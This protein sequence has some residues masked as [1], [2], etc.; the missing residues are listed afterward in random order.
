MRINRKLIRPLSLRQPGTVLAIGVSAAMLGAPAMAQTSGQDQEVELDTLKIEGRTAD[1][2]PYA[3][4]GAPYK[5]KVSGDARRTKPLAETPATIT[6]LTETAIEE[7]G[8]TDLKAILDAQPGITL[9]T[10]EGG[11]RFGD[12]YIIRGQETRSDVFVDGLRD[13]GMTT[14]ESFVVEQIEITKGPSATFAGRGASGGSV[15]G[16]TKQ[17]N[18]EYDFHNFDLTAGSDSHVRG[19]V[20]SNVRLSD[21]VA[22]RANLLYT[23]DDVPDRGVADRQRWGAALSVKANLSEA[24]SLLADYYHLDVDDRPDVGGIIASVTA[25]GKPYDLPAYTQDEDFMKSRIDI[26]TARLRIEPFDGFRIENTA[27]YGTVKNRYLV[28]ELS[29]FNR[30]VNDPYAGAQDFRVTSKAA[31]QNVSYFADQLNIYGEFTT[32]GL[33]H[34]LVAGVEY[35]DNKVDNGGYTVT[36]GTAA[37]C[38]SGNGASLNAWCI[39]DGTGGFIS[40]ISSLTQRSYTFN[41][42]VTGAWQVETMAGYV[43]DTIDVKP[44]LTLAGGVRFDSFQYS[45]VNRSGSTGL[46]SSTYRYHGTLWNYNASVTLKPADDGIVFFSWATG[47]DING[48]EADVGANCGYG[49]AC[50]AD[51]VLATRPER[52]ENYELGTKWNLFDE[53]LL[54]TASVFRTI[55]KDISEAGA[56]GSYDP[57]GSLYSGKHRV[58]GIELGVSGNIT[59]RLSAQAGAAFMKSKVLKSSNA[60]VSN[61]ALA[62]GYTNV[63]RRLANF[64][65]TSFDAQLRYQLTDRIAFGGNMTYQSKMYGGQPDTAAAYV[66]DTASPYFGEYSIKVPG[67][68]TY[69]AFISYKV[70]DKLSLRLNGLNL[71]DKTYY[72][73]A[74]RSGKFAYL[75]DG[76]TV[77]L[78]LSGKF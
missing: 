73:A 50:V 2:N 45:L 3:E 16:I 28:S 25:G 48:G 43:M 65:N 20:D 30:G 58:Q 4:E 26:A 59:E 64:A 78:T 39:G 1:V 37:N 12:R 49:G 19:T 54:L 75:G 9:G 8:R 14:R 23:Q 40:D 22:V 77:R 61:A 46:V 27:R 56:N 38:I 62:A 71:T 7:S 76:R 51:G 5:A 35:T 72:V 33:K 67:H 63:G 53:K 29:A 47:A 55:K 15:N 10:G 52:S 36:N 70:N 21:D 13:P 32:G 11:N 24:V 69:D 41:P 68:T 42:I 74:Y 17:A 6:V 66:S 18:T 34:N 60:D 57:N 44:W 31:W